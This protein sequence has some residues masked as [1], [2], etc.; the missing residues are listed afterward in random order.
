MIKPALLYKDELN[1]K[2]VESWYKSE[3]MYYHSGPVEHCLEL[4]DNNE[5]HQLVSIDKNNEV[6]GYIS[7]C[8]D[9]AAMSAYNFGIISYDK[10][11][12][13]FV[14]DLYQVIFDL[15]FKYNGYILDI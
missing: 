1:K 6:I 5:V 2:N 8:I 7:Y 4:K 12:L 13:T 14:K 11:N 9:W 3:N 15:F 10:G